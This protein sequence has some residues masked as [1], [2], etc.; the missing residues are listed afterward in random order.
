MEKFIK[1]EKFINY[2]I[3]R[4]NKKKEYYTFSTKDDIVYMSVPEY[5]TDKDIKLVL[6]QQFYVLYSKMH[7]EEIYILHYKGKKYMVK[8]I[9]SSIDKVTVKEDVIEIKAIKITSRYYK[10]VLHKFFK[11]EL[12]S[13]IEKLMDEA[14]NDFKEIV[15]PKIKIKYMAKFLGYNYIDYINLSPTIM[16]YDPKYI[17][18]LLYHELCHSIIRGHKQDFWDLLD[19]KLE[20]GTK[21]NKEMNSIKYNDYL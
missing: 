21:L 2:E 7:K 5:A 6:N 17:K 3:I 14:K 8:C 4:T 19:S 20:N 13:E 10:S 11:Q 9:K 1:K 15:I 12:I 16:K 18:V